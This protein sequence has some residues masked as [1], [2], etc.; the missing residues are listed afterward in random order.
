M[1]CS[2]AQQQ[3]PIF[4]VKTLQN[5]TSLVSNTE[6]TRFCK[7]KT[8]SL[9][10]SFSSSR[11]RSYT[12]YMHLWAT[13][14]KKDVLWGHPQTTPSLGGK[15]AFKRYLAHLPGRPLTVRRGSSQCGIANLYPLE[16][17]LADNAALCMMAWPAQPLACYQ[18]L[19]ENLVSATAPGKAEQTL[20][21][22]RKTKW[23]IPPNSQQLK[24][25]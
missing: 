12:S 24:E 23:K 11:T 20:R 3:N 17:H 2:T 19:Q 10:T 13:Q 16:F 14:L 6:C 9:D 4:S 18:A 7:Y 25:I 21:I 22:G 1:F 5:C 8:E 15:S